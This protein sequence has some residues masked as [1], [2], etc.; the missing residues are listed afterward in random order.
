M[1][2]DEIEAAKIFL[3]AQPISVASERPVL[4]EA[5]IIFHQ[6]RKYI[7]GCLRLLL[8]L[9]QDVDLNEDIKLELQQFLAQEVIRPQNPTSTT[10]YVSRCLAAMADIKTWLQRLADK[11]NGASVLG[12]TGQPE[13]LERLEYER[14][15]LVKQHE[16]LGII[17]VLLD[18]GGHSKVEDFHTI[19]QVL[20]TADK[21][22]SLLGEQ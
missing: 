21:Y 15:S 12:Q 18:K 4:T 11:K 5:V 2:L 7:L 1:D 17:L 22:D 19:L 8:Q 9:S 6:Q 14:V 20:R 10:R 16:A 13:V 3:E